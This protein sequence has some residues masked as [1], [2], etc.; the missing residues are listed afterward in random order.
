MMEGW[1]RCRGQRSRPSLWLSPPLSS[2]SRHAVFFC[3]CLFLYLKLLFLLLLMFSILSFSLFILFLVRV[4]MISRAATT[5]FS[6]SIILPVIFPLID[7]WFCLSKVRNSKKCPKR[8]IQMSR[9]VQPSVRNPEI[10]T[11][12]L[13]RT[14]SSGKAGTGA[15]FVFLL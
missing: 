5:W 10:F 15:F 12:L 2:S 1:W 9:F 4:I 6:L 7:Y 14:Q 11:S 8:C 3:L 13:F